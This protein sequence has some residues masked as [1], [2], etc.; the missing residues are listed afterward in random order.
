MEFRMELELV[1]RSEA[2]ECSAVQQ[3]AE[4]QGRASDT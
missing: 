4:S 3:L 1:R 2:K